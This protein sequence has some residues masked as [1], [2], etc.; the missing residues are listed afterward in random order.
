MHVFQVTERAVSMSSLT[1][2]ATPSHW[3][4]RGDQSLTGVTR[5]R[6]W[7]RLLD[8]ASGDVD[9][10]GYEGEHLGDHQGVEGIKL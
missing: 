3:R 2:S 8:A 9:A 1:R 4:M 10:H 5:A 7:V 6:E